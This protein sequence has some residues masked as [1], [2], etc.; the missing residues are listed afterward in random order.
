MLDP[1]GNLES[2]DNFA[3]RIPA[4]MARSKLNSW[5][6]AYPHQPIQK[7]L[8][9]EL[10]SQGRLEARGRTAVLEASK[11]GG[12]YPGPENKDLRAVKFKTEISARCAMVFPVVSVSGAVSCIYD[13]TPAVRRLESHLDGHP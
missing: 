3:D 9:G 1:P 4:R 6:F 11:L 2:R 13:P 5:R 7:R 8:P 12:Q 10:A